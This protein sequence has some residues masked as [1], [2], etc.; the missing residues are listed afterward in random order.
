M[1]QAVVTAIQHVDG[2]SREMAEQDFRRGVPYTEEELETRYQS[3][4][5]RYSRH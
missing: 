4:V 1:L 3:F 2:V 5:E